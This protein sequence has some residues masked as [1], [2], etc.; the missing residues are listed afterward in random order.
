M[1]SQCGS[2]ALISSALKGAVI[3]IA[4]TI[5]SQIRTVFMKQ[6]QWTGTAPAKDYL[7]FY[8]GSSLRLANRAGEARIFFPSVYQIFGIR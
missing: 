6:L 2:G 8:S 3:A 4:A 5:S 7:S 1:V